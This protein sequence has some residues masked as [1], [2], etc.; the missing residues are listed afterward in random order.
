MRSGKKGWGCD[1]AQS[2]S[3]NMVFLDNNSMALEAIWPGEYACQRDLR[4]VKLNGI[5]MAVQW[6]TERGNNREHSRGDL[7]RR[8]GRQ[9]PRAMLGSPDGAVA[10]R[11]AGHITFAEHEL[12]LDDL[13]AELNAS[14]T[15]G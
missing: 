7:H 9:R 15:S 3:F 6:A 1:A 12:D 4:A 8:P 14:T 11:R 13:L 2:A 5:K 10:A